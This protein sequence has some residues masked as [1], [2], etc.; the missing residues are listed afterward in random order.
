MSSLAQEPYTNFEVHRMVGGSSFTD[1][2]RNGMRHL[3][4]K[5]RESGALNQLGTAAKTALA[6]SGNPYGLAASAAMGALGYGRG[7]HR[8]LVI[9]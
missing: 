8:L 1:N 4:S 2:L 9:G 7:S 3:W 6:S 5:I